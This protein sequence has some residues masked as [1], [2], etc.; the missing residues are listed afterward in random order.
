MD[1]LIAILLCLNLYATPER[2]NDAEFVQ[3]NQPTVDR[4]RTIMDNQWYHY[5]GDGGVVI[6]NGV[7]T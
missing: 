2:L 3:Q 5:N 6:D 4:A 1:L 7:G